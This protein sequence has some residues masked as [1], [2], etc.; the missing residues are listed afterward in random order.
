MKV[1]PK[2]EGVKEYYFGMEVHLIYEPC[3]Y[4]PAARVVEFPK[5]WREYGTQYKVT[6]C[7]YYHNGKWEDKVVIRVPQAAY[8]SVT[9]CDETI[10][11]Y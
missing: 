10:E 3:P 6:H 5:V 7:H 2:T 11:R 4:D 8:A 1:T 9:G